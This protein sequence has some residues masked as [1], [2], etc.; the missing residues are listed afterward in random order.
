MKIAQKNKPPLSEETK[1]KIRNARKNQVITQETK[2]KLKGTLVVINRNG[3]FLK[4]SKEIYYS[5]V[6]EK[7]KWEYVSHRSKEA[8]LRKV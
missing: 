3:E 2:E 4:I 7:E 1:I 5:Q 6:G 8:R